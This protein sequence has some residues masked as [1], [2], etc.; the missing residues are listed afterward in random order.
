[1]TLTV[2]Q[3]VEFIDKLKQHE[4]SLGRRPKTWYTYENHVFGAAKIASLIAS[5]LKNMNP[6]RVYIMAL[7]H[8]ISRIEEERCNRFHGILGYEKFYQTDKAVARACLLHSF[9]WNKLRPYKDC[10]F[11]FYNKKE[12]YDFI[13]DFIAENKPQDEDYLLQLCD[14][15]A[16]KNGFVTLF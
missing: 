6:Q 12:D 9:P 3:A 16:N 14:N 1:M 7:L 11:L 4:I 15:L 2:K 5:Q 8:D 10:S 13:A